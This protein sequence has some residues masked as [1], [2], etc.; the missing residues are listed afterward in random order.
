MSDR[1]IDWLI[2]AKKIPKHRDAAKIR[3]FIGEDVAS[4]IEVSLR[5]GCFVLCEEFVCQIV[6]VSNSEIDC[7]ELHFPVEHANV[8]RKVLVRKGF[9]APYQNE[10]EPKCITIIVCLRHRGW[11]WAVDSD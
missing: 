2:G 1:S 6:G 9:A 4:R 3:L 5:S 11:S 10:E 7:L 8:V